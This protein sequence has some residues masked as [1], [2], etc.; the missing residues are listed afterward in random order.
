M[1][2]FRQERRVFDR[3]RSDCPVQAK[4]EYERTIQTLL[5][6]FNTTIHENRFVVGG[7]V[8]VFT[9]ALLRTVGI[10]CTMYGSQATAGDLLLANNKKSVH[11]GELSRLDQYQVAQSDGYGREGMDNRNSV[12]D[13]WCRDCVRCAGHGHT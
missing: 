7:A 6:R 13:R 12:R 9:F 3:L 10:D 8:E 4:Q 5:K 2:R 11:P 1:T